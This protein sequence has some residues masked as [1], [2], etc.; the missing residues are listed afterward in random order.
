MM[1]GR[2][3]C[4]SGVRMSEHVRNAPWI[5]YLETSQ[6]GLA[7]TWGVVRL[8]ATQSPQEPLGAPIYASR[9]PDSDVDDD[10]REILRPPPSIRSSMSEVRGGMHDLCVTQEVRQEARD[11]ILECRDTTLEVSG[12]SSRVGA[13]HRGAVRG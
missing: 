1:V 8:D 2:V 13:G 9:E 10:R 11:Y 3:L 4:V 12:L 5:V 7:S 6:E